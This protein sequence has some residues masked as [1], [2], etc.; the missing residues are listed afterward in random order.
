MDGY[1]VSNGICG[2]AASI[3]NCLK[4]DHANNKC[5]IC[6]DRYY[7]HDNGCARV[8]DGCGDYHPTNGQCFTCVAGYTLSDST[9]IMKHVTVERNVTEIVVDKT[10]NK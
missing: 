5:F 3:P 8:A 6:D 4:V 1:E 10:E 9:C 7:V 2:K